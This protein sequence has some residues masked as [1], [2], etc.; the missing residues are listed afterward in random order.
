MATNVTL[1]VQTTLRILEMPLGKQPTISF[2]FEVSCVLKDRKKLKAFIVKTFKH[3]KRQL[4]SL[5]YIFCSDKA[6][7]AINQSYLRHDYY[8]DIIT[9]DLSNKGSGLVGEVYISAE[10]VKE[11]AEIHKVSF[12]N[13]LHRVI[14]HGALHLCGYKDKTKSDKIR[15]RTAEDQLLSAYFN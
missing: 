4:E 8:T 5:T 10:R 11:N 7:L 2:H 9:F 3:E 6:L 14:F 12:K 13:E 15:M 1:S